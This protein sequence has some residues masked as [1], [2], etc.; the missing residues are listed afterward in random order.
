MKVGRV[1]GRYISEEI[2]LCGVYSIKWDQDMEYRIVHFTFNA[3]Q[4]SK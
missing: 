4:N 1:F 2:Y 3:I